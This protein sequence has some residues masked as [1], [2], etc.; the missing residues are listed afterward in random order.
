MTETGPADE[1]VT[2]RKAADELRRRM[3]SAGAVAMNTEYVLYAVARLLEELSR[4]LA[5]GHHLD[6]HATDAALEIAHHLLHRDQAG[7]HLHQSDPD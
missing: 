7:H 3:R 1:A 2:L 4:S 5:A 6:R